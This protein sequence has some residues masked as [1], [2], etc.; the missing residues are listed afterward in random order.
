MRFF[1]MNIP[2]WLNPKESWTGSFL[3]CLFVWIA[4][5]IIA[6]AYS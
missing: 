5:L 1:T 4:G 2:A 3:L 6:V